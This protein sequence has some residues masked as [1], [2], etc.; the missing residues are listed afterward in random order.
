MLQMD[1]LGELYTIRSF[2]RDKEDGNFFVCV[3]LKRQGCTYGPEEKMIQEE[4]FETDRRPA[5]TFQI[6]HGNQ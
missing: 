3:L 2:R 6:F 5:H 4:S 1:F